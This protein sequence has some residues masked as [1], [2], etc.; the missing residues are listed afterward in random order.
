MLKRSL[1]GDNSITGL[2]LKVND[3]YSAPKVSDEL[4]IGLKQ[5]YLVSNW[6]QEYGEL[7]RA[8]KMEKTMM[9]FIFNFNCGCCR[10]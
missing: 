8:I 4:Q 1:H 3:L 10:F 7:F 2:R 9:F 6:T 5:Q